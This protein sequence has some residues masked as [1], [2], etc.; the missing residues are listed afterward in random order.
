M[1]SGLCSRLRELLGPGWRLVEQQRLKRNVHR[2]RFSAS[3]R[4]RSFVIKR[5]TQEI[6]QRN[7]LVAHR[8]LPAV[9]LHDH[10]PALLALAPDP[11]TGRVW[12]IQADLGRHELEATLPVRDHVEA[13]VRVLAELHGRFVDHPLLPECRRRAGDLGMPFYVS[14]VSDGIAALRGLRDANARITRAR[15]R[16]LDRLLRLSEQEPDRARALDTLGGP[17]TVLHGDLWTT[18]V[19]LAAGGVRLID[20]DHVGVGPIPYDLSTFLARFPRRHRRWILEAYR[21][22][23]AR[24]GGWRLPS[25]A[26][27]NAVFETA[28]YARLSCLVRWGAEAVRS[29]QAG[30]GIDQ[31]ESIASWFEAYEPV[32]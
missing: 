29:G 5:C 32:L 8:W 13:T 26:E 22:E 19:V 10:G 21:R 11:E 30:W 6:A 14:S 24:T 15:D 28:E 23:A 4:E 18:N 20:W 27:L 31:L 7:E 3:G 16:L 2:L 1:T 9:G 25:D 12:Q 17:E